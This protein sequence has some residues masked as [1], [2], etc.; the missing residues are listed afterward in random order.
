MAARAL[1]K[2]LF[3]ALDGMS[4]SVRLYSAPRDPD[5]Q[6]H[7]LHAADRVR[8]RERFVT[9]TCCVWWTVDT[10]AQAAHSTLGTACRRARC[11]AP[12]PSRDI[13]VMPCVSNDALSDP[14]RVNEWRGSRSAV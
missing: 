10:H 8:V 3:W 13:E 14:R 1:W 5:R 7:W 4:V 6:V 12:A 9:L 2:T 11:V